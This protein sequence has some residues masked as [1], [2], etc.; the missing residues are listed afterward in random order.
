MARNTSSN[1]GTGITDRH[2]SVIYEPTPK[3][4]IAISNTNEDDDGE[5]SD[6]RWGIIDQ[7]AEDDLHAKRLLK[8]EQQP[9]MRVRKKLITPTNPIHEYLRRTPIDTTTSSEIVSEPEDTTE[10]KQ[11]EYLKSLTTFQQSTIH[12]FTLLIQNIARLQFSLTANESERTRYTTQAEQ[13]TAQ[14]STIR[15]ETASL[16]TNLTQAR[17]Q[18]EI[19]KGYDVQAE[20]VLWV[21]GKV[22]GTKSKT[23]EELER[24]SERL[25]AEIEELEREGDELNTQW[26][27][28]RN[29]LAEVKTQTGRLRRIV[30]G[31]VEQDHDHDE[32]ARTDADEGRE[33][34][35]E[36]ENLATGSHH[37]GANSNVGTPRPE[38]TGTPLPVIIE[39]G[40]ESAAMT[41][42]PVAEEM[43]VSTPELS[44]ATTLKNE[45]QQNLESGTASDAEMLDDPDKA[46]LSEVDEK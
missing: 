41:P 2:G 15:S 39:P 11:A 12:D 33:N 44:G 38:D 28:R 14:Q 9:Y 27:E 40:N 36:H 8:F 4:S 31:E 42:M 24:E 7:V 45:T 30:R 43:E 19:R 5:M 46:G 22:G 21:D 37:D 10:D 35:D 17:E 32:D 29:G 3:T 23:R 25:R 18:L 6:P 16:R 34:D 26:A 20:K 1:A 13:V